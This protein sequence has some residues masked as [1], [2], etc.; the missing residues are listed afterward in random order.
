MATET[1]PT[2]CILLGD[3]GSGVRAWAFLRSKLSEVLPHLRGAGVY[4]LLGGQGCP[5]AYVG[6]ASSLRGRLQQHDTNKR[7]DTGIAGWYSS[8]RRTLWTSPSWHG[9][10]SSSSIL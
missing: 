4:I 1:V 10:R 7:R 5:D 8:Q 3:A 2:E 6:K 9:W